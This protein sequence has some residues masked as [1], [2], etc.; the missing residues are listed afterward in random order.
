MK[1]SAVP[2]IKVLLD[3]RHA[4]GLQSGAT[5]GLLSSDASVLRERLASSPLS[6]RW[7]RYQMSASDPY[8]IGVE[9]VTGH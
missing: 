7:Q 1:N 9:S 6:A 5:S 8:R 3:P 4:A 2:L